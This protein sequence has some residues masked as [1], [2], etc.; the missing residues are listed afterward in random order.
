MNLSYTHIKIKHS[1]AQ[2]YQGTAK[3]EPCSLK[4]DQYLLHLPETKLTVS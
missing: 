4:L 2:C 1:T 3:K